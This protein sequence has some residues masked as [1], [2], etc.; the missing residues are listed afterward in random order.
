MSA[1]ANGNIHMNFVRRV[2][3]FFDKSDGRCTK[4]NNCNIYFLD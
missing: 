1:T 2:F 3:A 4:A